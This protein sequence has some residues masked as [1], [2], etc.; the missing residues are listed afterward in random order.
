MA[1]R[2]MVARLTCR[3]GSAEKSG[4]CIF[5]PSIWHETS[6][7]H[8]MGEQHEP[9]TDVCEASLGNRTLQGIEK[10]TYATSKAYISYLLQGYVLSTNYQETSQFH[11]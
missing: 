6:P 8:A 9:D 4:Q 3:E 11:K 2:N 5:M 10:D 1:R 7:Q